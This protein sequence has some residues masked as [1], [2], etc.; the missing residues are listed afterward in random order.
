MLLRELR[1][2][3]PDAREA[4]D[5]P[6]CDEAALARTY[7]RFDLVNAVVSGRRAVYR[8]WVRP[9]LRAGGVVRLL[10]VGTGGADL[11]RRLLRWAADGELRVVAIDPDPRAIAFARSLPPLPGL[12][13]R[14][15]MT[16]DLV[17]ARER[18]DV[19]LSNHVLH[20]LT[21]AELGAIL[22]DSEALL[23]PGGVAVHGDIAR[24]PLAFA[25]FAAGT[26]PFE[27][28]LLRGTFIRADGLASIRR[29]HT[30]AEL[31]RALPTGWAVRR[32]TP[33]RYELVRHSP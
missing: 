33:F 23:S 5:D 30:A 6:A 13:L 18:F 25:A 24:S 9:R 3:D 15:A 26:L 27:P 21:G 8:R 19:V 10:D 22:A 16:G 2:R 28:T 4:M 14:Q 7:A 29:S 32:S 20:H 31:A 17:A 11:P 1:R 12:E